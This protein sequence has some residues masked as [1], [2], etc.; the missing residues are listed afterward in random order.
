MLDIRFCLY[1]ISPQ[2]YRFLRNILPIPCEDTL[3]RHF[4]EEIKNVESMLTD[5]TLIPELIIKFRNDHD[6]NTDCSIDF[7]LELD[8]CAFDRLNAL[9]Q[10]YSFCFYIQPLCADYACFPI[11]LVPSANG[12]AQKEIADLRGSILNLLKNC[13]VNV[14]AAATDGD[15]VYNLDLEFTLDLYIKRILEEGID[16][17]AQDMASD[18]NLLTL[19]ISDPLHSTNWRGLEL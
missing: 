12:T 13:D 3:Y 19:F 14:F 11:H 8:A 7:V 6:L 17:V 4:T 18:L 15:D 16:Q 1:H 2:T 9:A 5:I 10:K